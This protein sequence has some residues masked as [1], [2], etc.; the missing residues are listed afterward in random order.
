MEAKELLK[1][2][3]LE[4]I[5]NHHKQEGVSYFL[6]SIDVPY[7]FTETYLDDFLKAIENYY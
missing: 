6:P 7:L 1:H 5:R 2:D 3:L 4:I